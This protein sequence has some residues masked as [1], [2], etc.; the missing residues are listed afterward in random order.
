[1]GGCECGGGGGGGVRTL[2]KFGR[3]AG[4]TEARDP[5]PG[6]DVARGGREAQRTNTCKWRFHIR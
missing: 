2:R 1:M 4:V 6:S 3:P 5:A